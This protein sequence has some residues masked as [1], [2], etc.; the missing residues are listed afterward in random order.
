MIT[1]FVKFLCGLLFRRRHP[2]GPTTGKTKSALIIFAEFATI[3]PTNKYYKLSFPLVG[4]LSEK[5]RILDKP[6]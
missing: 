4:N 2:E 6:E 5:R 3:N 1:F